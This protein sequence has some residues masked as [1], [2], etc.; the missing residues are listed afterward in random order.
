MRL[1]NA[2][3]AFY[4][5][6]YKLDNQTYR[7]FNYR[8]ASYA[9]FVEPDALECRGHMF[10]VDDEQKPI[11]IASWCQ[12]KFF[13]LFE[14]PMTMD[15]DLSEI[16]NI[17]DKHDGSLIS[18]F[19]HNEKLRLKSKGSLSSD[20]VIQATNWLY[21][22]KNESYRAALEATTLANYT[23]NLEW[24]SPDNRIV[25]GYLEPKLIVLNVRCNITGKLFTFDKSDEI[26]SILD[27]KNVIYYPPVELGNLTPEEFVNEIPNMTGIEGY[28]IRFKSGLHVKRKCNW[29]LAL[30][31]AKDSVNNPRRLF[32]A[33]I[34]EGIDDLRV[35]FKDDPLAIRRIDEM[36]TTVD[37]LYNNMV[38][39]VEQFYEQNKELDRK[40]FAIKGQ[41]ELDSR[42]FYLA[43]LKFQNKDPQYKLYLK[44]KWKLFGLKDEKA[45]DD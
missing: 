19:I 4:F 33:I 12:T 27:I 10:E 26:G 37:H 11:R 15:L 30:H 41:N 28:I 43:M 36:Q 31:H 24:T 25:L 38:K 23:V 17:E 42:Y 40:S 45:K 18:T 34:D 39:S 2:N 35:M 8:L 21:L 3:E 44:S 32:E 1:V 6:D 13:N 14:N 9:D 16:E 22:T 29:Y 5:Q 7:I 20:Q